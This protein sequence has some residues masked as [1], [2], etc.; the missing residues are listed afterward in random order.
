MQVSMLIAMPDPALSSDGA[1]IGYSVGN[2]ATSLKGKTLES[3]GSSEDSTEI[4]KE[5]PHFEFG[6]VEMS[7]LPS[8]QEFG[9][10]T[11]W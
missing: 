6:M 1:H 9:S 7:V 2:R 5:F 3:I 11:L 4:D 8:F 10:E